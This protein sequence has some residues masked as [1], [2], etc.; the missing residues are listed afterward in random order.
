MISKKDSGSARLLLLVSIISF[1]LLL[2]IYFVNFRELTQQHLAICL[3]LIL[4][5]V[6]SSGIAFKKGGN[7]YLAIGIVL[8]NIALVLF[9][10]L[11]TIMS[12]RNNG[13]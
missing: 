6:V 12:L 5:S 4:V 3:G 7:R 11:A 2:I 13:N 1:A 9:A 8:L 10:I